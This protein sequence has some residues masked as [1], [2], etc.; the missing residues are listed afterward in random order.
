L[1]DF[2]VK[3]DDKEYDLLEGI[4]EIDTSKA[5]TDEV[6]V[7]LFETEKL[8]YNNFQKAVKSSGLTTSDFLRRSRLLENILKKFDGIAN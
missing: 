8:L 2:H 7:P 5:D 6:G 1:P 3:I 4:S